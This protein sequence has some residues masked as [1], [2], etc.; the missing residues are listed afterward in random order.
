MHIKFIFSEDEMTALIVGGWDDNSILLKTTEIIPKGRT[1][2]SNSLPSLPTG[3]SRQPS[4]VQTSEEEIL[5]CGGNYYGRQKCLVLKDNQWKP[6]SNLKNS[7]RWASAV[8]MP[9]GIFLFG[10]DFSKTTWEWL[11]S[12]TNQWQHGNTNIPGRGLYQG[13]AVKI[14]RVAQCAKSLKCPTLS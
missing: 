11:S 6:H 9:L 12:E 2:S 10:G 5:L 1:C 4:L 8:S 14:N 7:R 3:I 13:C